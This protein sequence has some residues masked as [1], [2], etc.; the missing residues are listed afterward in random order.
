MTLCKSVLRT[1]FTCDSCSKSF[2][3]SCA[4]DYIK[5]RALEDCCRKKFAYLLVPLDSKNKNKSSQSRLLSLRSVTSNNSSSSSFKSALSSTS[6]IRNRTPSTES[7]LSISSPVTPTSPQSALSPTSDSV[8]YPEQHSVGDNMA[9]SGSSQSTS[10]STVNPTESG[11]V[12]NEVSNIPNPMLEN[13]LPSGW[14]TLSTDDKLTLVMQ[15]VAQIPLLTMEFKSL[16]SRIDVFGKRLNELQ[17]KQSSTNEVLATLSQSS[18]SHSADIR[19][20]NKELE[21]LKE[22]TTKNNE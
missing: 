5:S 14:L 4:C 11:K 1:P 9:N 20:L 13:S 17:E 22:N 6:S 18:S 3:R 15:S 12:E 19:K 16:S 10:T 2:H 8:F 7:R 21:T